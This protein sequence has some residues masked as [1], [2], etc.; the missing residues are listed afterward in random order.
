MNEGATATFKIVTTGLADKSTIT[1]TVA[2]SVS[3]AGRVALTSGVATVDTSG[4]ALVQVPVAA[5]M[6]AD[7]PGTLTLTLVVNSV[8]TPS[9]TIAINDT[10][11]AQTSWT[12][13]A[14]D[15]ANANNTNQPISI[16]VGS[17]GTQTV[18]LA[19]D[20]ITAA[21]GFTVSGDGNIV[22]TSGAGADTI[23]VVGNGSNS[24]TTGGGNDTVVV[25]GTGNNTISVGAGTDIVTAGAG[26]DRIIIGSGDLDANDRIDGGAG[27][28]TVV[29]SGNGNV[30]TA[31]NLKNIQNIE[32]VGTQATVDAAVLNTIAGLGGSISGSAATTELTITGAG[33]ASSVDLTK[34]TLNGGFKSITVA[35]GAAKLVMTADQIGKTTTIAG[36]NLVTVDTSVAGFKALGTKAAGATVTITDTLANIVAAGA[37]LGNTT[38]SIGTVTAA[39]AKS[40]LASASGVV[41]VLQDTPANLA[42]ASQAVIDSATKIVATSTMTASQAAQLETKVAVGGGFVATLTNLSYTVTDTAAALAANPLGLGNATTVTASTVANSLQAGAINTGAALGAVTTTSSY[43]VT[44]T[45]ANLTL[46]V[47]NVAQLA[48]LNLASS[49]TISDTVTNVVNQVKAINTALNGA[50]GGLTKVAPGYAVSGAL[51]VVLANQAEVNAA[52]DL[53]LTDASITVTDANTVMALTNTGK[54]SYVLSDTTSNLLNA[55]ALV[56]AATTSVDST[57]AGLSSDE[58][59]GLVSKFGAA[60]FA[61]TSLAITGSISNLMALTTD[62]L[63][64]VLFAKNAGGGVGTLTLTGN[65]TVQQLLD[66]KTKLGATYATLLPAVINVVDTAANIAAGVTVPATLAALDAV[67]TITISDATSVATVTAINTALNGNAGGLTAVA[68]GYSLSDTAANLTANAAAAAVVDNATKV[69]VTGTAT[70]AQINTIATSYTVTGDDATLGTQLVYSLKD[71]AANVLTAAPNGPSNLAALQAGAAAISISDATVT[72]ANAVLLRALTKFDNKYAI[73]SD[74]AGLGGLNAAGTAAV[75]GAT[76]VKLAD[77]VANLT[78]AGS[79][80][81]R[82][83]ATTVVGKDTLA[84]LD[85]STALF[86]SYCAS[87]ELT[88]TVNIATAADVTK[89]VALL[90][91]K[92]TVYSI[93]DGGGVGTTY[94][95]LTANANSTL[96]GKASSIVVDG[97]LTVVQLQTLKGLAS[98]TATLTYTVT[99]TAAKLAAADQTLLVGR[100][101]TIAGDQTVNAAQAATLKVLAGLVNAYNIVDTAAAVSAA[102]DAVLTGA[103]TVTITDKSSTASLS[104]VGANKVYGNGGNTAMKYN[105]TIDGS[106]LTVVG[107]AVVFDAA[108]TVTD[109]VKT[110]QNDTVTG[111]VTAAVADVLATLKSFG[112]V[113]FSVKDTAAALAASAGA[114]SAQNIEAS[115]AATYAQAVTIS[116]KTNTGTKTVKVSD[117]GAALV[118]AL[119]GGTSAQNAA[120]AKVLEGVSG[121]VIGTGNVLGADATALAALVKPVEYNISDTAANLGATTTSAG[122]LNEAKNIVA[123]GDVANAATTKLLLAATNSGTTLIDAATMSS[124]DAV[125]LTLTSNDTITLLTVSGTTTLADATTINSKI[126]GTNIGGISFAVI[127]ASAADLAAAPAAL[128]QKGTVVTA[129]SDATIAQVVKFAGNVDN[130]SIAD[131]YVNIMA[132]ADPAGAVTNAAAIDAATKVTVTSGALTVAEAVALRAL[133]A[134]GAPATSFVYSISDTNANIVASVGGNAATVAAL[135]GAATVSGFDG[136]FIKFE[137]VGAQTAIVGTPAAIAA[138]DA[139]ITATLNKV[140][141]VSVADLA[142]NPIKYSTLG[143]TEKLRVVDT[144]AN[145]TSGNTVVPTATAVTVTDSITAAQATTV[146]GWASADADTKFSLS[147]TATNLAAYAAAGINLSTGATATTS[148]TLA[149][150]AVIGAS[151]SKVTYNVTDTDQVGWAGAAAATLNKATDVTVTGAAG[152]TAAAATAILAAT[153]SGNTLIAKVT[154]TAADLAALV[155]TSND[156]ITSAVLTNA[157]TATVAQATKIVALAGSATYSLV[158]SSANLAA[159]SSAVLNGAVKNGNAAALAANDESTVAQATVIDAATPSA[160]DTSFNITDTASAVLAASTTLLKLDANQQI[161]V[162]GQ[163]TASQATQLIALDTALDGGGQTYLIKPTGG[164]QGAFAITD[165]PANLLATANTAAVTNAATVKV[166]GD[167]TVANVNAVIAIHAANNTYSLADTY[168]Q[169]ASNSTVSDAATSVTVTNNVNAGQAA[170]AFAWV[171][172]PTTAVTYNIV[173]SATKIASVAAQAYLTNAATVTLNSAGTVAEDGFISELKNVAGGYAIADSAANVYAALNTVNAVNAADRA[174]VLGAKTIIFST[175]ATVTQIVGDANNL[176]LSTTGAS[177]VLG[178]SAANLATALNGTNVAAVQGA[179]SVYLDTNAG[180]TVQ[181]ITDLK[182]ALGSSFKFFDANRADNIAGIYNITDTA[183]KIAVADS[184]LITGANAVVANAANAGGVTNLS[185]VSKAMTI[186]GSA[187]IDVITGGDG[188]DTVVGGAGND[189]LTGGAGADTFVFA[190]TAVLNGA[191]TITDFVTGTDKLDVSAFETAGVKVAVAGNLTTAAG[192]VYVLTGLAAGGA[193]TAA[194]VAAAL[195]GAGVWT[196]AAATA[197]VIVSDDNSSAIYQFTDVALSV[198]EVA[199][200]ELTLVGT[201]TGTVAN[202]DIII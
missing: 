77:T 162:S 172:G 121:T 145:L 158:D 71:T 168:A 127:S 122:A 97:A 1:Y 118:A 28:N 12:V 64:E 46:G 37:T 30:I 70:I 53:T 153:N 67:N 76:S 105:I 89:V 80:T 196:A 117:T 95:A 21:R 55:S 124:S 79:D 78:G 103:G 178:D 136:A 50:V 139:S 10:S 111:T 186:N 61:D 137:T 45:A 34:T 5:N 102:T 201:I 133:E 104:I 129:T 42:A 147:D 169:L 9:K 159:A 152:A 144:I 59:N 81:A 149:E 165:T 126:S 198:D 114:S 47:A 92:P 135:L 119:T 181:N 131:S 167:T 68:T 138:L 54:D 180:A 96:V 100:T 130:Y 41:Y 161:L 200:A 128:L 170:I 39:Q 155:K 142:A 40:A 93:D 140:Y 3:T 94:A 141:V 199:E 143:A 151:T 116:G 166:S 51:A 35:G 31:L 73:Q 20:A 2:D 177:Y 65:V 156:T 87:F 125:G 72:V 8:V 25:S 187:N 63:A 132:K 197:W 185:M 57:S 113:T 112:T 148:A 33:G 182:T 62:S 123:T 18:S 110:S 7:G 160:A 69:T 48:G 179:S 88:D 134:G 150:A 109:L 27:T 6:K 106:K 146:T 32:F 101:P 15:I 66:L 4:I 38:A 191:D 24:I 157:T 22:L 195:S 84:N 29:I 99:D 171:G 163:A 189:N 85:G 192:T 176:G 11:L 174:T 154:G 58:I 56:V 49:V 26:N 16:V 115:T 90:A 91:L 82:A 164:A 60:K 107:G 75:A 43:A 183:A 193:D 188:A 120:A 86:K 98:S 190:A 14:S 74:V 13:S 44:D 108:I 19:T 194:A 173:D 17:S 175:D 52:G 23:T 202:A 184:A 36:G 83:L